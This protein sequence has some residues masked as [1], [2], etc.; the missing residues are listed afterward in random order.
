MKKTITIAF[1]LSWLSF[2][3]SSVAF[4]A[5]PLNK[6]VNPSFLGVTV[7]YAEYM[8][9]SPAMKETVDDLGFQWN[10]YK[11]KDCYIRAGIKSGKVVSVGMS[12]DPKKGCDIDVSDTINKKTPVKGSM[13][14]FKDYAGAGSLHFTDPQFPTCNACWEGVF[15]ATIDGVGAMDMLSIQLTGDS[16]SPGYDAWSAL[17]Y[18]KGIRGEDLPLTAENCPLRDIDYQ[19]FPLL[20]DTPVL[21]IAYSRTPRALQPECSGAAVFWEMRRG[22]D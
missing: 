6:I 8:I 13:T 5:A 21:G 12:F 14:T 11:R 17:R 16:L 10:L 1:L 18:K 7:R 15:Y 20:K 2:G 9:G 22:Q 4:A 19:A 3:H